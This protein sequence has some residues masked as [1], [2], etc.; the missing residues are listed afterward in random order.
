[1]GKSKS[2]AYMMM[3]SRILDGV[4]LETTEGAQMHYNDLAL[5]LSV[6]LL[7]EAQCDMSQKSEAE[8]RRKVWESVIKDKYSV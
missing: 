7:D 1:M 2:Q 4:D 3:V 6:E 8:L 5:N